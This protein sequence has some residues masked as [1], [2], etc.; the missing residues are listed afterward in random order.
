MELL[1]RFC[2]GADLS[3]IFIKK[4]CPVVLMLC[5]VS[6]YSNFHV[7]RCII[8]RLYAIHMTWKF[9]KPS[10][11]ILLGLTTLRTMNHSSWSSLC[12]TESRMNFCML[13]THP[14][15]VPWNATC[16]RF[17]SKLFFFHLQTIKHLYVVYLFI[18]HW[19]HHVPPFHL[20]NDSLYTSWWRRGSAKT[21]VWYLF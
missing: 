13:Y 2:A 8:L 11:L 12:Q 14:G 4:I 20:Y 5:V 21:V 17:H 19:G 3:N 6:L 18:A 1:F 9:S 10:V 7:F 15:F 16:F